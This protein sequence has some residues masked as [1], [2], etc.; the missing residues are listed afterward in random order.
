MIK[1]SILPKV[2]FIIKAL[3]SFC[4]EL[5]KPVLQFVNKTKQ[6]PEK[7]LT[8]KVTLS[9]IGKSMKHFTA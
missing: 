3:M 9:K 8:G 4:T 2:M 5:Q 7:S 6:E 1:M